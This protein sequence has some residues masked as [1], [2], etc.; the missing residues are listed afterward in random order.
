M[1]H[2][3]VTVCLNASPLA[4]E[5][6]K[7]R[8]YLKNLLVSN[9]NFGFDVQQV[10]YR[11]TPFYGVSYSRTGYATRIY[12]KIFQSVYPSRWKVLKLVIHKRNSWLI[13]PLLPQICNRCFIKLDICPFICRTPIHKIRSQTTLDLHIFTTRY[14]YPSRWKKFTLV[15]VTQ[16][17]CFLIPLLAQI[18]FN[19]N[20]YLPLKQQFTTF[21]LR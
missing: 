17:L 9:I 16:L 20:S 14:Y 5:R 11:C 21:A 10:F 15:T 19:R 12:N 1:H 8:N 6:I 4:L 2:V 3:F 18:C 7:F 13:I